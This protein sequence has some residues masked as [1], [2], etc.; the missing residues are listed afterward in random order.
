MSHTTQCS[1][2]D[3]AKGR[4]TEIADGDLMVERDELVARLEEPCRHGRVSGR[5]LSL[6]CSVAAVAPIMAGVWWSATS[7]GPAIG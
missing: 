2:L 4:M 5:M 1:E 7:G 3:A 6:W